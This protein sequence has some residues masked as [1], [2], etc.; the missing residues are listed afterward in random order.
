MV[1]HPGGGGV[2]QIVKAYRLQPGIRQELFEIPVKIARQNGATPGVG[3][4]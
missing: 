4:D 1:Q 2:T 3:E